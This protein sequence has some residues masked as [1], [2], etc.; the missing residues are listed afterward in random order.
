MRG[1]FSEFDENDL[2]SHRQEYAAADHKFHG[3]LLAASESSELTSTLKIIN[4]RLHLNRLRMSYTRGHDLRPIHREHMAIIDALAAGDAM[5]AE[6]LV[7]AHVHNI[8]WQ[9]VISE[10]DM[11]SAKP[12]AA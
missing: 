10:P 6:N 5:A 1:C 4:L 7:R 12:S 3:L 8:P 2:A 11:S 9:I